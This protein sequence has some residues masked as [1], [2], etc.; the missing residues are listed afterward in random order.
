MKKGFQPTKELIKK[1][2][3]AT[4]G[5][6]WKYSVKQCLEIT[7]LKRSTFD[8]YRKLYGIKERGKGSQ[9]V[10]NCKDCDYL[11]TDCICDGNGIAHG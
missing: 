3:H 8:K 7:G 11:I 9:I 6:F 4:N 10:G 1:P 5:I 2:Y